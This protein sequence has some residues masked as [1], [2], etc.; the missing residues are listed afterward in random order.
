MND[1][2]ETGGEFVPR[3][4]FN[5]PGGHFAYVLKQLLGVFSVNFSR[6][7]GKGRIQM[8][9]SEFMPQPCHLC[10]NASKL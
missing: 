9:G 1:L 10:L 6:P 4:F 3:R 2:I 8:A 7:Y 5:E